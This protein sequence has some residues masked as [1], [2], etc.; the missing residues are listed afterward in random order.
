MLGIDCDKQL[1]MRK[2][3]LESAFG[4]A[5]RKAGILDAVPPVKI[6]HG[7]SAHYRARIQ[8]DGGAFH[9]RRSNKRVFVHN[10]IAA[11]DEVNGYLANIKEEDERAG[12]RVQVFG[13]RRV[14][15]AAGG[16]VAAGVLQKIILPSEDCVVN[17]MLDTKIGKK[18]IKTDVRGFFQSNLEM[19]EKAIPLVC[20]GLSGGSVLDMYAGCG[21]FSTFLSDTFKRITIVEKDAISVAY[22][23]DNLKG[24][25]QKSFA[26]SGR[27]WVKFHSQKAHFDAAVVDP[28]RSGMEKEVRQYLVNSKIPIIRSLSCD[29]STHAR[30]AA[31]LVKGGYKLLDL[32]LLDFYPQTHRI[33]S[34][35]TLYRE[36][37][38]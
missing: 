1:E 37:Y 25:E 18:T 30:D 22:A 24:K 27:L 14:V 33:E 15:N 11:T 7:Q 9:L 8:L 29:E 28:P 32:T 36:R 34:L 19:L 5:F 6:V 10:C 20:S 12:E 23:Q 21:T 13:D 4:N 16:K 17:V 31:S 3:A 38:V 2:T 26:L 35:A